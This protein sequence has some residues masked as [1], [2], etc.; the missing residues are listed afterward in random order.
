MNLI[1]S[2]VLPFKCT[3]MQKKRNCQQKQK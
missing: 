2:L 1:Q 3:A